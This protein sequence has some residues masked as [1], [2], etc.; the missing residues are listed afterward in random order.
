M[1]KKRCFFNFEH[2][3]FD[4][5]VGCFE[6]FNSGYRWQIFIQLLK[7]STS[8]NYSRRIQSPNGEKTTTWSNLNSQKSERICCSFFLLSLSSYHLLLGSTCFSELCSLEAEIEMEMMF[9][10]DWEITHLFPF[11]LESPTLF[12]PLCLSCMKIFLYCLQSES[13]GTA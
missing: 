10:F 1:Q 8:P 13:L 2:L 7:K 12:L 9:F 6:V 3:K 11:C 5:E 4:P